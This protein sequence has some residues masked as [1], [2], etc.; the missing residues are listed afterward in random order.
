MARFRVSKAFNFGQF[1]LHAGQTVA[2]SAGAA[3]PGDVV[4]TGLSS[5]TLGAGFV[6]LDGSATTMKSG[7]LKFANEATP[8]AITGRYS[9]DA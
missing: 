4:W 1:H 8:T 7:S 5:A 6:P 2:D 3:Q 9:I